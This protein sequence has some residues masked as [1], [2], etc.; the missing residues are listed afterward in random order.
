M[1]LDLCFVGWICERA[2]AGEAVDESSIL[3]HLFRAPGGRE[4]LALRGVR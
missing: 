3:R 1:G 2:L 4:S